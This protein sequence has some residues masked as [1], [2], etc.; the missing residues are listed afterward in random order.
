MDSQEAEGS[1]RVRAKVAVRA[2]RANQR[3]Q[4]AMVEQ[5]IFASNHRLMGG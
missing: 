1:G 3:W 5:W 2:A 4:E